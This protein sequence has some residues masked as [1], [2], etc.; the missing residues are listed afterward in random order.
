MNVVVLYGGKSGEHDVSLISATSVVRNID[1][2]KHT[3]TLVGIARDGVWY[4]QNQSLLES[5][6][7]GEKEA[8][9]IIEDV[10]EIVTVQP[11]GGTRKG[12]KTEKESLVVDIVLPILHGTYGEDGL[13]QGLL[14]MAELPY[15]GCGVMS[16]AVAM[17]KEK[18]KQV[19][20]QEGIPVV[21][22][23]CVRTN[24]KSDINV[25]VKEI[26]EKFAYPVFVK[27]V[28][29]GSSVGAAKANTQE[30]LV[31][32]IND[33]FFWDEKVLVEPFVPSREIECS[34][35]G[36]TLTE[37]EAYVVKAYSIG[38]ILPTHEFYDYDAKY[39]DPDGALLQ[40]PAELSSEVA[41][42][43]KYYAKK[44]YRVLDCSGLSRVD[45]FIDKTNDAIYLN[46]INT[47]PGFTPI[48]M[49]PMLCRE[50]G[51]EYK[52]LID[53]LLL[54]GLDRFKSR[55]KISE[56]LKRG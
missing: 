51:L 43:I 28:C 46:E 23:V 5:V 6:L 19:W 41:E 44:A 20:E 35:T 27:P 55:Q 15:C 25:V 29:A 22:Y 54:Q 53:Y 33:A 7:S 47:L 18:A 32:T 2:K 34:V 48:S 24:Q 8:L 11:G 31:A 56:T 52:D 9:N 36:N 49:F 40:I 50:S 4:K 16:S 10:N 13:L 42:K 30:E 45:F 12:L 39:T 21:P 1:Y 26:E 3:V 17:D 37:D 38:E 14:E